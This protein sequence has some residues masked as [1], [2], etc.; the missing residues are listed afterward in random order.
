MSWKDV[1]FEDWRGIIAALML[2]L[3]GVLALNNYDA[4]ATTVFTGY[5]AVAATYFYAKGET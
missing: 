4:L 3:T 5:M 2:I 1:G